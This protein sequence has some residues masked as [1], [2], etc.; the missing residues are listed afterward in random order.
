[1]GTWTLGVKKQVT[2][3]L[4][5]NEYAFYMLRDGVVLLLEQAQRNEGPYG[6][7]QVEDLLEV[8]KG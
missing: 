8:F 2:I 6:L 1:M 4:T 7:G 3:T 5:A